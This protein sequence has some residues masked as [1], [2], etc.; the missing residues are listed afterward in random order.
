MITSNMS[1]ITHN[2]IGGHRTCHYS[3]FFAVTKRTTKR[4]NKE[5]DRGS[6]KAK[7]VSPKYD[8]LSPTSTPIIWYAS[9][10]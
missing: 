6:Y 9:P 7:F 1:M 2:S 5:K 4:D 3:I 8:Q 10:H